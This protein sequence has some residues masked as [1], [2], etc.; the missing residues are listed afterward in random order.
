[1]ND[2]RTGRAKEAPSPFRRSVRGRPKGSPDRTGSLR[3]PADG[4]ACRRRA[5][6]VGPAIQEAREAANVSAEEL[7]ARVGT[8]ANTI[9]HYES[10][11]R[12]PSLVRLVAIAAALGVRVS[13]L[14]TEVDL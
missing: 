4:D 11:R 1:M 12:V 6:W 3:N 10:G 13:S 7:G 5:C 2:P 14:C 8:T 9:S